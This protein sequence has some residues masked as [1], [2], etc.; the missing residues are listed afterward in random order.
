M[1]CTSAYPAS[2]SD[3]HLKTIPHMATM[4]ECM[5]GLS[6]HTTG[7]GVPVAATALGARV[8]EK[9][10]CLDRKDGG[11]DSSFSLEPSEFTL[12][13]SECS[14]AYSSLGEVRYPLT[15]S[16]DKKTF[17][18]SLYVVENIEKGELL[19]SKNIRVIR[20]GF[21]LEPKWLDRLI[22]SK[23]KRKLNKGSPLQFSDVL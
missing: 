23:A 8:I 13:A 7:I 22:G 6:D 2:P 15:V 14:R 9:H 3:A 4:F 17:R 10:F 5:T 11:V 1:K 12:M 16:E 20:P 19:S 21:G 18:R